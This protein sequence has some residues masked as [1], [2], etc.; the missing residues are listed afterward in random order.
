M[1]S[2]ELP[3]WAWRNP[4]EV[5]IRREEMSCVG[6]LFRVTLLAIPQCLKHKGR[7]GADMYRCSDFK[8]T[9]K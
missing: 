7:I 2:T 3:S 6:C 1:K 9:R 8:E 5:A 4:E